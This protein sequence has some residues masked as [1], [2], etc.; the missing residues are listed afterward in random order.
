[1]GLGLSFHAVRPTCIGNFNVTHNLAG[2]AEEA[3]VYEILWK[4]ELSV[5]TASDMIAPLEA[6]IKDMTERKD[7][8]ERFNSPNGWGT[9][10]SFL[11]W[12]CSVL[13]CCK[14][15]PDAEVSACV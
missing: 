11:P 15:N 8:Y 6:A 2:M 10:E 5:K 3:G 14:E 13:A 7:Y 12:L 1:M 9:Y 4:P